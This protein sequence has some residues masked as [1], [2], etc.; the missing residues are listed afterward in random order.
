MKR[1][2]I[3]RTYKI[4][5]VNASAQTNASTTRIL[6]INE[7]FQERI[8]I[9]SCEGSRNEQVEQY[10][11]S[12]KFSVLQCGQV[13]KLSFMLKGLELKAWKEMEIRQV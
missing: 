12:W 2:L 5:T 11:C 3:K 6:L 7:E 10:F 4:L 13:V 9:L 8:L 1:L